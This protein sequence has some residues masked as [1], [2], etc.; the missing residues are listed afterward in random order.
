MALP[1]LLLLVE[2]SA[3]DAD[4]MLHELRRAGYDPTCERVQTAEE[5]KAALTWRP[6]IW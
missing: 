2:D 5:L 1:L 4:L 6:G 3:D